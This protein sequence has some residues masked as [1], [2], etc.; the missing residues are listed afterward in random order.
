MHQIVFT[1]LKITLSTLMN[2]SFRCF[3]VT[4]K[5]GNKNNLFAAPF[6]W[7]SACSSL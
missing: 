1:N 6:T 3:L 4:L 7:P 2:S 5:F